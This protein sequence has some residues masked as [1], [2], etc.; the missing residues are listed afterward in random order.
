MDFVV[1]ELTVNLSFWCWYRYFE[2]IQCIILVS[3]WETLKKYLYH[4][5]KASF[6]HFENIILKYVMTMP[7]YCG[8][9]IA[10]FK[11][12]CEIW[13]AGNCWLYQVCF[14]FMD[15][16]RLKRHKQRWR[17][18]S[19]WAGRRRG[20]FCHSKKQLSKLMLVQICEWQH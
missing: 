10:N 4:R 5:I 7:S 3:F 18:W 1:N 20:E 9:F 15:R 12:V 2:H 16:C 11:Q 14:L 8:I 13:Q 6:L 17:R 19:W